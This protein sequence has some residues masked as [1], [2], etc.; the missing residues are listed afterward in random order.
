MQ[1]HAGIWT[2]LV[3]ATGG[4]MAFHKCHWQILAW[5]AVG[6]FYLM[7]TDRKIIGDLHLKDH[8]GKRAL[9]F[10]QVTVQLVDQVDNGKF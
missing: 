2:A 1:H 10:D 3:A 6:G 7:M 9:T 5:I 4:L 8:K